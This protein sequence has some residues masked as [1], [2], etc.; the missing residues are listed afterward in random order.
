MHSVH[1]ERFASIYSSI[2]SKHNFDIILF[3]R[4]NKTYKIA[5]PILYCSTITAMSEARRSIFVNGFG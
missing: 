5:L 1:R 2:V 3:G 4:M